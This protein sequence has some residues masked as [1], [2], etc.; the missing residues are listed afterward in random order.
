MLTIAGGIVL[1]LVAVV[2]IFGFVLPAIWYAIG[3]LLEG[4]GRWLSTGKW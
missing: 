1:G 2:V 4:L 3:E